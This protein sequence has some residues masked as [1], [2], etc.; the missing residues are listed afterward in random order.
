MEFER[1]KL[2]RAVLSAIAM[3]TAGS[4]AAQSGTIDEVL[5]TATKRAESTQDIAL[6]VSALQG[7]ALDELRVSN[8]DDYVEHLPNVVM[9]GR[10]PRPERDLHTRCGHRA[11]QEHH[12]QH[13]GRGSGDRPVR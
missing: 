4:V 10:R 12:R 3:T 7:D 8:F 6:S 13:S 9:M 2:N 11:V 1:S 5:V